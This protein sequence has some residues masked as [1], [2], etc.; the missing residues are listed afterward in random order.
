MQGLHMPRQADQC[1]RA[2]GRQLDT[3]RN[4]CGP[5]DTDI[6]T[7]AHGVDPWRDG[8]PREKSASGQ[9]AGEHRVGCAGRLGGVEPHGVWLIEQAEILLVLRLAAAIVEEMIPKE[10]LTAGSAAQAC[11]SHD[12]ASM[13]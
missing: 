10:L 13:V 8:L 3:L 5:Q 1:E 4:G 9:F 12:I 2:I 11:P 7:E 6:T